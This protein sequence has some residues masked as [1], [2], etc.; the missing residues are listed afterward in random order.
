MLCSSDN[1]AAPYP[2]FDHKLVPIF[3]VSNLLHEFP[4]FILAPGFAN[5]VCSL[6]DFGSVLYCCL[7]CTKAS[8]LYLATGNREKAGF[9]LLTSTQYLLLFLFQE[10]CLHISQSS[11]IHFNFPKDS[12]N[13][14]PADGARA[15]PGPGN[16]RDSGLM[17]TQP[18]PDIWGFL[19]HAWG[20]RAWRTRRAELATSLIHK[21]LPKISNFQIIYSWIFFKNLEHHSSTSLHAWRLITLV[22][23]Q[24]NVKSSE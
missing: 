10:S 9:S 21:V 7:Q 3:P 16:F 24:I 19:G 18:T 12:C 17:N 1:S 22:S 11:R 2:S 13:I 15:E 14:Q 8:P 6:I 20:P 4:R 23:S 5:T